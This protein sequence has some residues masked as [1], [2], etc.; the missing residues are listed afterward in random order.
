M[1]IFNETGR[2]IGVTTLK[3]LFNYIDDNRKAS[4]YTLNTISIYLG[5][6]DWIELTHRVNI[7]SIQG[8][9]DGT[10][11]IHSLK[12]GTHLDITYL[13][14]K[15]TF[16]VVQRNGEN[17]LRVEKSENSS[18]KEGDE[19]VISKISKGAIVEAE[20]IYRGNNMGNYKTQGEVSSIK[21][22]E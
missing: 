15:V 3:R 4:D 13:N 16:I 22:S 21:I 17:V 6:V 18:L 19:C 7:N 2:T 9:D 10:V 11:Y 1:Y 14:R 20:K 8:Y 5:Y 12:I